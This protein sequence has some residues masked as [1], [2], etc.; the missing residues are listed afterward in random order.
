MVF[1]KYFKT[2]KKVLSY[3]IRNSIIINHF[4]GRFKKIND[5]KWHRNAIDRNCVDTTSKY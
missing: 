5:C 3:Y 2:G 1:N 4:I